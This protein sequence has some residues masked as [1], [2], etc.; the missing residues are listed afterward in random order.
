MRMTTKIS[1]GDVIDT[2]DYGPISI[3]PA[4]L[5]G[6]PSVILGSNTA[7]DIA[8]HTFAFTTANAIDVSGK[9]EITFD[10]DYTLTGVGVNDV[11]GITG[12]TVA[13]SGNTLIVTLGASVASG[14]EVALAIDNIKNPGVQTVDDYTIV[15][16]KSSG[17]Q[18]DRGTVPGQSITAGSLSSL[19]AAQG[20][21]EVSENTNY[22]FD[23]TL[24]HNVPLNGYIMIGFDSNYTLD[25][26]TVVTAGYALTESGDDYL[27]LRTGS[28]RTGSLSIVINSVVNPAFVSA[29]LDDFTITTKLSNSNVI[30]AGTISAITT[31]AGDL[32]GITISPASNE[33]STTTGYTFTFT[34]DHSVPVGGKVAITF[35]SDYDLSG[36]T[37]TDVSGNSGSTVSATSNVLTVTL[38]ET[39]AA[40]TEESLVI[41]NIV[42]PVYVQTTDDFSFQTKNTTNGL[43][44]T[45]TASGIT[46]EEGAL[47]SVSGAP[48]DASAGASTEYIF[49]FVPSHQVSVSGHLR[50]AFD[51]EYSISAAYL[52]SP[53][54]AYTIASKVNNV[55]V[56]N[57]VIQDVLPLSSQ[58]IRIG[59]IVNP[60]REK[61]GVTFTLI[62]QTPNGENL[63]MAI[64]APISITTALLSSRS[65]SAD[66]YTTYDSASYTFSFTTVNALDVGGKVEITF[67][68][69]YNVS[70]AVFTFG[71]T[72]ATLSVSGNKVIVTLGTAIEKGESVSLTISEII[73]PGV[74]TVDSYTLLTKDSSG[75]KV[76]TGTISGKV[77]T[78]GSLTSMSVST[79][80]TE[81]S[82]STTYTFNFTPDHIVPSSGY[83]KITFDSDYVL[84]FSLV[85]TV[86]YSSTPGPGYIL[87]TNVSGSDLS[88]DETISIVL[89]NVQN[90]SSVEEPTDNFYIITMTQNQDTIDMNNMTGVTMTPSPIGAI[91]ASAVTREIEALTSYTFNMTPAH[92]ISIGGKIEITFDDD[93]N[94]ALI[95]SGDV[96]GNSGASASISG[97]TLIVT[98]GA[99][100][101]SDQELSLIVSNV[102][103]PSYVQTTDTFY[104]LT[105]NPSGGKMDSGEAAAL[106][107]TEGQLTSL[108][109]APA[110]TT[111]DT[112]TNYL[113]QFTPEH[114]IPLDG[115]LRI[116]FDSDFD[117]TGLY[118]S[119]ETYSVVS[120]GS[121]Y[122]L[123]KALVE[124]SSTQSLQLLGIVNPGFVKTTDP[125]NLTTKNAGQSNI[126]K[127]DASGITTTAGLLTGVSVSTASTQAGAIA[128]YAVD[129]TTVHAVPQ[130]GKVEITFDSDYDLTSVTAFDV[131]GNQDSTVT[132][133]GNKLIVNLGTAISAGTPESLE[134]DNIKNPSYVQTTS[135]F[136]VDTKNQTGGILD[137]G[138]QSGINITAGTLTSVSVSPLST[139]IAKSTDYTFSFTCEHA[140]SIG[141]Y[142][143]IQLDS[144]YSL[145]SLTVLTAGYSLLDKGADFILLQTSQQRVGSVSISLRNIVN[146]SYVVTTSDFTVITETAGND[147]I[148]MGSCNGGT[149]TAAAIISAAAL[150][151]TT[152]VSETD[153]YVFNITPKHTIPATG[154][155]R[156]TF[157]SDYVLSSVQSTDVSGNE[158]ATLTI[159]SKTIIISL[160]TEVA[161]EEEI[162]LSISNIKNPS[163]VQTTSAFS[164]QTR[165][166]QN[167]VMDEGTIPGIAITAGSL[168]SVS[169]IAESYVA[170][171]ITDYT[172]NFIPEHAV[173][174]GGYVAIDFDSDYDASSAY[175]I[176]PVD[177]YTLSS[178]SAN[179]VVLNVIQTLGAGTTQSLVI[180]TIS[181]PG[182]VKEVTFTIAT[183]NFGENNIDMAIS[184]AVS[185]QAAPMQNVSISS[186]S[187]VALDLTSCTLVFTTV[188]AMEIG[189]KVEITFDTDYNLT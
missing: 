91:S 176:S 8:T 146:P 150:P 172:F 166:N 11:S 112:T 117:L 92:S 189:G 163:Y 39:I 70:G 138:G 59:G 183:Q 14:E 160:G 152:E 61:T 13:V 177:V 114:T 75:V 102:Q 142:I 28:L 118:T 111:L 36:V 51:S 156:I 93:Y 127:G 167:R 3:I 20:T 180:G 105:K 140:L 134:I 4:P 173:G 44:D 178:K 95:G 179:Q 16:K 19:S 162:G 55:I 133:S 17:S 26:A 34:S 15:T 56:L 48:V 50:I 30:D 57:V 98:L 120:I 85:Q 132:V 64:S 148:D 82:E 135:A 49:E 84:D 170:G 169:V 136:T 88:A 139:E 131:S 123:L 187:N 137:S 121:D 159:S 25:T 99:V 43:I 125:F 83:V 165:D 104:V 80:S 90:P 147:T 68:T 164:I 77:I 32:S 63:D 157:D 184:P 143:R 126:D 108:S 27:T 22:T 186:I 46:T 47:T 23:F 185:T 145:T 65:V 103:N 54:D 81:P 76:D 89:L 100:V 144:S 53:T 106:S 73:N 18:I 87:L 116:D 12:S 62:T 74:Q 94:L 10:T 7:S 6:P 24:E 188:N 182:S 113:F 153:D 2:S 79:G 122:V 175:L 168:T 149:T 60:G 109:A 58:S 37:S 154:E 21:V 155:I 41:A 86:G 101:P 96:S 115:Y 67:D 1:S 69:D 29:A 129:F 45:A 9:I 181:N 151:T 42:N 71:N 161:G 66:T 141:G 107:I 31:T 78:G 174:A 119:D 124:K 130:S 33:I 40:S 52:I 171:Y 5:T 35:D 38:G 97:K 72:D 158:G 110:D 128:N